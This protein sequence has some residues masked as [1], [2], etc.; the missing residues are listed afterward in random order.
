MP[1][2]IEG[3]LSDALIKGLSDP[4]IGIDRVGMVR[5]FNDEAGVA[6]GI[7]PEDAIGRKVWEVVTVSELSRAFMAQ[8]KDSNPVTVEQVMVFPNNRL[9][10]VK[11]QAVR[12]DKGRNL[13]AVA[14]LRDMAGIQKIERGIDQ[15]MS[16]L[17]RSISAPLTAIKGCVETLLEGAYNDRTI[18]H[19]FLQMIND[20]ANR[21]VRLVMTLE[22]SLAD[23]SAHKLNKTKCRLEDL[24]RSVIDMFVKVAENHHVSLAVEFPENLPWVEVDRALLNKALVNL[25]DNAVRYTGINNQGQIVITLSQ[26]ERT[27][28]IEVKDNGIGIPPEE[29]ERIFERFYRGSDEKVANL[30]G[31]GLGLPVAADIVKAHGGTIEVSSEEGQ[32]STFTVVL[33]IR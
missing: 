10:A 1:P 31:I 18:T 27:V 26:R 19:R 15:I 9:F 11:V 7:K 3:Q 29:R 32:G 20:E 17:N 5:V 13:G 30:G 14:V 2:R 23:E 12:T 6:L 8:I 22:R 21:L 28:V 33:P 4:A 24:V 25:V 16:D